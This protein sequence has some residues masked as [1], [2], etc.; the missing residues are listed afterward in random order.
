MWECVII[1]DIMVKLRADLGL[2]EEG[3]FDYSRE[4]VCSLTHGDVG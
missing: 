3:K 4:S 1:K 2:Y